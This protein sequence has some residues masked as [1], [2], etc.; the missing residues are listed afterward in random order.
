MADDQQTKDI[1]LQAL[2]LVKEP[3]GKNLV[4]A[5]LVEGFAEEEGIITIFA[6][7]SGWPPPIMQRVE[8]EIIAAV[9]SRLPRADKVQVEWEAAATSTDGS[10]AGR[11][12]AHSHAP[13]PG[14]THAGP[15]LHPGP[16]S[17][18]G[19]TPASRPAPATP[20]PQGGPQQPQQLPNVKNIVAVGSGK[21]GVGKSTIAA[22]LA[23]AL[24]HRG[25]RVGIMDA[26]VYGPSIP[27][28]LGLQ[29]QAQVANN[30]MVP[31]ETDGIKVVSM[32]FLVPAEQSII[33]R[34][35]MLHKMVSQFLYAVEWGEL[36][37]LVVDLPPGTGDVVLS[38]SQLI[39]ISAGVIVCTPQDVALLD[40]RKAAHM[41]HTVNIPCRGLVE[42]MSFFVCPKCD[43]RT[44]I[45]GHGGAEKWAR[46]TG[47]PFLGAVPINLPMRIHGD[48]GRV[49]DNFTVEGPAR[50]ALFAIA[51]NLVANMEAAGAPEVPTFEVI[52]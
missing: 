46:E 7:Q 32:G 21:G 5:R 49:R 22:S 43:H 25:A 8:R 26:D 33:W 48:E 12:H 9:R 44:E 10:T 34:G 20:G 23:Y 36:D 40:A 16:A 14:H 47:I 38:L 29:G 50:D 41:L 4:E 1:L 3:G 30:R 6:L 42:N 45:F 27:H 31:Y 35:P 51:D 24:R 19:P 11:A 17:H 15:A 52:G 39:P 2:A 13:G 37:Y 28:M 18:S